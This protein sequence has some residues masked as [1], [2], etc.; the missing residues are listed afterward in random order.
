MK[1]FNILLLSLLL[2]GCAGPVEYIPKT[3]YILR[4]ASTEQKTLPT[5]P[6]PTHVNTDAELAE[7]IEL[8]EQ[9]IK[10]LV[11]KFN[12]LITFYEAPYEQK[13]P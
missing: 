1:Y 9:Y 4:T 3:E 12:D 8:N 2:V 13:G 6:V 5:K 7:F 11:K 10:L